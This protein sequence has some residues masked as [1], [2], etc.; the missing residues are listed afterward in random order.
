MP[1]L[2]SRDRIFDMKWTPKNKFAALMTFHMLW[3]LVLWFSISKY[4]LGIFYRIRRIS[5]F[6]ALN[7]SQG[8]GLFSFDGSFVSAWP[9]LYPMLLAFIQLVLR[10]DSF[11]AAIILQAVSFVGV[12]ICLSIIFL[13]IFPENFLLALTACILSN[14][15]NVILTRSLPSIRIICI[16]SSPCFL[17]CWLVITWSANLHASFWV[18]P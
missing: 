11:V 2:N 10:V 1:E 5:L 7:V 6:A 4:G 3:G 8:K 9:P 14:V 17:S 16:F 12:S 15:G 18:C 13:K